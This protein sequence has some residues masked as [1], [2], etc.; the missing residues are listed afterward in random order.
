[1]ERHET[2]V[3]AAAHH[4]RLLQG[5]LYLLLALLIVLVLAATF[6]GWREMLTHRDLTGSSG[7][8]GGYAAIARVGAEGGTLYRDA[9]TSKPPVIF[10]YLTPFVALFGTTQTA[11]NVALV[12]VTL[13]FIGVMT[14]LA[15][16]LSGSWIGAAVGAG[17]AGVYAVWQD[18]PETTFLMATFGAGALL[19]ALSARGRPPLLLLAGLLFAAGVF[20]KQPLGIELPVLLAFAYFNAATYR[21]R[22]PLWVCL[23]GILGTGAL[24]GWATANGILELMWHRAFS[25][26]VH[27]VAGGDGAWHF[28]AEFFEYARDYFIPDTLPYLLPLLAL[29]LPSAV[30]L[31]RRRPV[32]LTIWL[33]IAWAGLAFAGGA[34]G[35]A[36]KPDYFTQTLPPLIILAALGAA[37][38]VRLATGWQIALAGLALATLAH[39]VFVTMPPNREE[40]VMV[41]E[42]AVVEVVLEQTPPD[43]CILTW[44]PIG[45]ISY[46]ADRD[47]CNSAVNEGFMMDERAFPIARN[48]I[49]FMNEIIF[50]QP[51]VLVL[52][53]NWGFFDELERYAERYVREPLHDAPPY[54]VYRVDTSMQHPRAVNFGGEVGLIGYDLPPRDAYCPGDTLDMALTWRALS[55]PQ[56]QYQFFVQLLT[57]DEGGRLAG[58]D[59]VPSEDRATNEWVHRGEILLGDPFSIALPPDI[60]PGTYPLVVGLYE[61]ETAARL[62]VRDEQG[63]EIGGYAPLQPIIIDEGC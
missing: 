59:G 54:S 32:A 6:N 12:V 30:L 9:W 14:A 28:R 36:L 10:F 27:Y 56:H 45:F 26:N 37:A 5:V 7:D 23:G 19:A 62:P 20:T 47:Q 63:R 42:A 4:D 50:S 29:A 48:R 38:A 18:G 8:Y 33:V 52:R 53:S 60:A 43:R 35:R 41:R 46:L 17:L 11:F 13:L 49:D 25:Q 57:P 39:F 1:M 21:W 34:V 3:P 55:R 58:Y 40:A 15:Y 16:R 22:A 2:A 44:G 61:V 24:F 51:T 31:L